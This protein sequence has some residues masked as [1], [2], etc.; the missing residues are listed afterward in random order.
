M[1]PIPPFSRWWSFAT[2]GKPK[3]NKTFEVLFRKL[4]SSIGRRSCQ[5]FARRSPSQYPL[6]HLHRFPRPPTK[7]PICFESQRID[8]FCMLSRHP[9]LRPMC[10]WSFVVIPVSWPAVRLV[11]RCLLVIGPGST[12]YGSDHWGRNYRRGRFHSFN[13]SIGFV[14]L[15]KLI[16]VN[17]ALRK[18]CDS[19]STNGLFFEMHQRGL[20]GKRFWEVFIRWRR[21]VSCD[22]RNFIEKWNDWQ[23]K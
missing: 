5:N 8:A 17:S 1:Y 13:F 23:I 15:M 6:N 21:L 14:C 7:L 20:G 16:I 11:L 4:P 12:R 2:S 19:S 18:N 9:L 3:A 10:Y 22:F